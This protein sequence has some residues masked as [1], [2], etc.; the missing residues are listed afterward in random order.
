[1][2]E[3]I[4]YDSI[5]GWKMK[6]GINGKVDLVDVEGIAVRTN[7]LGFWDREFAHKKPPGRCRIA[8][9]GDS[10]TWG[11][12]VR[13]EERF[14]NLLAAANPDWEGF[15]FG[16]PGYGTDQALL[17][18]KHMAHRFQPDLVVLTIYQND[19]VDNMYLV[20]YGRRKPYF[21]LKEDEKTELRNVPV[22]PTD[23]WDD[24]IFHQPAPAYVSFFGNPIQKRS[25]IVHWLAKNSDLARFIYTLI[26]TNSATA[27]AQIEDRRLR[28]EDRGLKGPATS[29]RRAAT[30]AV[31]SSGIELTSAQQM[32]VT[33]LGA[34]VQHLAK[35]VKAAGAGFLVVLSGEPIPEYELQK[36]RFSEAGIAYLEATTELLAGRLPAGKKQVYYRYNK[37]WTPAAHRVVA[38]L[39]GE[40]IREKGLCAERK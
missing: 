9:L 24:G 18:W 22:D 16:V 7:S 1:M 14:T 5:L 28:I 29:D 40:T 4:T 34:V 30:S 32:Q 20:R 27:E 39:I 11:M 3:V 15:N 10:F 21:E 6:P 31:A 26:R 25:R 13:E 36:E 12:G 35:E 19:Y 8:F 38:D 17:L 2:F 37:H 33:L 23:F